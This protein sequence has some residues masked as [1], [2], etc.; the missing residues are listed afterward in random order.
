MQNKKKV[1]AFRL[2]AN[3][4]VASGHMLRCISIA[5][6]CM[7]L[8]NKCIFF[9]STDSISEPI[10]D[11]RLE[12]YKLDLRWNDWN[13][14]IEILADA[15]LKVKADYLV[16]DSY[17]VTDKFF[18]VISRDIRIFYLDDICRTKYDVNAVLHYSEWEG[19]GTISNLY[20]NS[21]VKVFFG[22][23]YV[24]LRD[25]FKDLKK[26]NERSF[27]LLIT[28]GGT[29]KYHVTKT[30]LDR[31]VHD[32]VLSQLSVCAVLG[33]MN[34]DYEEI[35]SMVEN[36]RYIT[37][38]R[39]AHNISEIM[40]NSK[41]AITAGGITAYELMASRTAFAIFSFS[42]DQDIFAKKMDAHNC[43]NYAGDMRFNG[44]AVID[45]LVNN[46]HKY[47]QMSNSSLNEIVSRNR[48]LVDGKG[49]ERI[50]ILLNELSEE[51]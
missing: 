36:N 37:I 9:I 48:E 29:D 38:I 8:G 12:Y 14:G 47:M 40:Q 16:V 30:L 41:F 1:I 34:S 44:D 28:T 50:A 51:E 33:I 45:N 4:N 35:S 39:N 27:D 32:K 2:D 17:L 11:A 23:K 25:E 7:R 21:L 13:Y 20:K 10:E 42:D 43:A 24:P 46:L 5:K 19:D 3:E 22:M 49:C 26:E 18:S 6:E 31:I 15:L